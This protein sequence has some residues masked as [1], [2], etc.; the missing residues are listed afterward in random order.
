MKKT[1]MGVRLR[2]LRAERGLSQIAMAQA[3]GLSPSYLNQLEQN[4][5]PLTVA[6]LLKVSRTLGVDVQQFSED[7]EARMVAGLQEALADNP[8]ASRSRCQ[9]FGRLPRRCRPWAARCWRCTGATSKRRSGW[10]HSPCAWAT[11]GEKGRTPAMPP[12]TRAAH[13]LRAR[14]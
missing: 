1:F 8:G 10:R 13:G 3:L 12:C 2:K 6:V 9:S 5:R 14:A 11:A 4:Q 7:E